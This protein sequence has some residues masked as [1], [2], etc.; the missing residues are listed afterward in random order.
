MTVILTSNPNAT[1]NTGGA[2]ET[3]IIAPSVVLGGLVDMF[4]NAL[5]H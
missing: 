2:N 3:F 4:G 5:A 1:Q